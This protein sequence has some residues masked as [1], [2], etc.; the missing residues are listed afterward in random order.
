MVKDEQRVVD[1]KFWKE[2]IIF[3]VVLSGSL[4]Y[5]KLALSEKIY[6]PD[7]ITCSRNLTSINTFSQY[8]RL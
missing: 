5:T 7:M 6:T 1:E 2:I 3:F 4:S 8:S